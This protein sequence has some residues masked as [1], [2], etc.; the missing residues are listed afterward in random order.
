M[1]TLLPSAAISAAIESAAVVLLRLIL[2]ANVIQPPADDPN[3]TSELLCDTIVQCL[4]TASKLYRGI[5]CLKALSL[6]Y[7]HEILWH[8]NSYFP[9]LQ[10]HSSPVQYSFVR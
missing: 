8:Q 9:E 10:M 5:Y 2:S 1:I 6:K 7:L 4:Y 3:S